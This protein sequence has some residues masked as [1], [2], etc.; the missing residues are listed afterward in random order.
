MGGRL[1]PVSDKFASDDTAFH[2]MMAIYFFLTVILML[3]VLI[4]LINVAFN[5]GDDSWRLTWYENR[6]HYAEK[7]EN[8][9]FHV[10]GFRRTHHWFPSVIYYTTTAKEVQKYHDKYF[11]N[12][13]PVPIAPITPTT[14]MTTTSLSSTSNKEPNLV[15]LF[16]RAAPTTLAATATSERTEDIERRLERM[17]EEFQTSLKRLQQEADKKHEELLDL[18]RQ[19]QRSN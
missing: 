17:E 10:P 3:N 14:T 11:G 19:Q 4:A 7:A 15:K 1:D 13:K 6:F 9:S 2:I 16:D 18:L 5:T 12:S 8:M